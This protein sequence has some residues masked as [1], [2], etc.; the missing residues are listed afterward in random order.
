MRHVALSR[1]AM[2]A[3]AQVKAVGGSPFAAVHIVPLHLDRPRADCEDRTREVKLDLE[4]LALAGAAQDDVELAVVP[5]AAVDD[6]PAG[7]EL[8]EL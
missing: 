5:A 6:L 2:P 3:K 7:V 4:L 8:V 1:V